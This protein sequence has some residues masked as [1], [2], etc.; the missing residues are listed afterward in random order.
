MTKTTSVSLGDHFTDFIAEQ[1]D[2]GRYASA[3]DVVRTGLRLLEERET[4]LARLRAE[5]DLGEASGEAVAF[6][7][8]DWMARKRA[9][10]AA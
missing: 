1:V 9:E 5:I 3:S 4:A 7:F 8:E 6:D 2:T 10:H